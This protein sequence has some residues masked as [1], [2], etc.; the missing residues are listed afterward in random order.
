M[1]I[2]T[3]VDASKLKGWLWPMEP[4]PVQVENLLAWNTPECKDKGIWTGSIH[5]ITPIMLEHSP[6]RPGDVLEFCKPCVICDG[7]AAWL[8]KYDIA[9]GKPYCNGHRRTP[10]GSVG[11]FELNPIRRTV[12][13]VEVKQMGAID[14]DELECDIVDWAADMLPDAFPEDWVWA[15]WFKSRDNF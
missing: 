1:Q 12:A 6:V 2:V 5:A 10:W 14:K 7:K 15:A 3:D 8:D 9:E 11:A 4:Q 13:R